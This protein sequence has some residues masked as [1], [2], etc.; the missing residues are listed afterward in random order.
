MAA[1]ETGCDGCG[2]SIPSEEAATVA[3][4]NGEQVTCCPQ[5][6]PHARAVTDAAADGEATLDQRRA[7]CDGCRG[8]FLEA[9]LEDVR[10]PDGA[11]ISC[12]PSCAAE[13]PSG[14]SETGETAG[15]NGNSANDR[16]AGAATADAEADGGRVDDGD[17]EPARCSQCTDP[18]ATEP[19]R[20]TTVDGRTERLCRACKENAEADGIIKDVEMRASRARDVLGVESDAT[21]AEIRAAYH[22][23][24]KRAHPDR[25]SGSRSAFQLV[26]DAYER[27]RRDASG[28]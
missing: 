9:E 4:P 17:D 21:L 5:C 25:K 3:M 15:G 27:L 16:A 8:S 20:V 6:A 7:A 22:Q 18:I 24:V 10:L 26:T 12:C 19:F 11:V 14:D 2:R 23:Q 28:Q 1:G 13:A